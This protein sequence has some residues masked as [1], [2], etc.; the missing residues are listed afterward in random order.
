MINLSFSIELA[1][2]LYSS[3][4]EFPVDFDNAWQWLGYSSKQKAK[5][6]LTRNFEEGLDFTVFIQMVECAD[7]KGSSRRQQINLTLDCF[8]ALGMMAGT[9]KG[10][11]VRSYFLQCEKIA[12]AAI[13]QQQTPQSYIDALKALVAS[14][15]AKL[16][17][18]AQNEQLEEAKMMLQIENEQLEEENEKLTEVVDELFEYSSIIR[19]AKFNNCSE[20]EFS[21]R[22][23]K[24]ASNLKGLEIKK[25]PCPRYGEKK[26]V[27]SRRMAL[28][29]SERQTS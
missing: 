13:A 8:K 2:E 7:S 19:V 28:R 4:E 23:L 9:D 10:K 29:L 1:Q 27:C 3:T 22:K 14:E 12:K 6:K 15:E 16:L 26:S 21:W 24:A 25:V 18:K 11:E 20:K 17:L 5:D